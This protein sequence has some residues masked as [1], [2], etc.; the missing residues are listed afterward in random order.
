MQP[1]GQ[2]RSLGGA[3]VW[4]S[5]AFVNHDRDGSVNFDTFSAFSDQNLAN[6]TFIGGF[7]FHR[8]FVSFDFS[9]NV[10]A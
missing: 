5:F 1:V 8:G 10:T 9:Q 2:P 3:G 6:D 4:N 7:K